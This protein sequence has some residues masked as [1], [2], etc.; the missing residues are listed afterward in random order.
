VTLVRLRPL[1][2]GDLDAV[3]AIE[4]DTFGDPW[5]KRSF[6]ATLRQPHVQG[7]AAV[8][9][10]EVL[11]GYGLS[12]RVADEAEILNIAVLAS[13]RGQG[14]GRQL[15]DAL[16]EGLKEG[17]IR[18]VFLE[19][20]RSNEAAIGLYRAV[21]FRPLGVRPAYYATPREDALTM[22]LQFASQTARK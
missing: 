17:G 3:V 10:G 8:D 21:G 16:L 22:S 11:V 14:I 4:E 13:R 6:A 2:A 18:T 20:R 7:L 9:A 12:T 1:A 5:S 19:V 15:V